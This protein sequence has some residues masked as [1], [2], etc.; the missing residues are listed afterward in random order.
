MYD[1]SLSCLAELFMDSESY[2]IVVNVCDMV[3]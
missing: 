2:V 1:Y 3:H